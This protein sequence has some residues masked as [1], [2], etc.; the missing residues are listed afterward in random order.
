MYS[1]LQQEQSLIL[2]LFGGLILVLIIVLAVWSHHLN[3]ARRARRETEQPPAEYPDGL[4]EQNNPVP[5]FLILVI[6]AVL[7]WALI[8]VIAVGVG[9][10]YVQ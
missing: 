5:L 3:L 8:Y 4:R 10:L 7:I 2:I 9:G 6:A 1:L